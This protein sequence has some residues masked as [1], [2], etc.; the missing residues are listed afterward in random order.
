M[1]SN[2]STTIRS[3]SYYKKDNTKENKKIESLLKKSE[4]N[5]EKTQ[6]QAYPNRKA[7]S[8]QH[9]RSKVVHPQTATRSSPSLLYGVTEEEQHHHS[10]SSHYHQ[11]YSSSP[12]QISHND[13]YDIHHDDNSSPKRSQ[14]PRLSKRT[15]P[16]LSP[17]R[18]NSPQLFSPVAHPNQLYHTPSNNQFDEHDILG[19]RGSI[20]SETSL[21]SLST[22]SSVVSFSPSL[23]G[24][25]I[26][27]FQP[28]PP[29]ISLLN[30][31]TSVKR[32]QVTPIYQ[33]SSPSN[34]SSSIHTTPK[35][36]TTL[37]SDSPFTPQ[38][39]QQVVHSP[40]VAQMYKRSSN[41]VDSSNTSPT[42]R[43]RRSVSVNTSTSSFQTNASI[44]SL[45]N[46]NATGPIPLLAVTRPETPPCTTNQP[47]TASR[48][49]STPK[50]YL[51]VTM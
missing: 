28:H 16:Q 10:P 48:S 2:S 42:H 18:S 46:P 50:R 40:P 32:N 37:I 14:S 24:V 22:S 38:I 1:G 5:Y 19:H 36:R 31:S 8:H 9:L 29:M 43:S 49:Q 44:T 33:P 39:S 47:N 41:I 6:K 51:S 4:H 3:P 25:M 17:V 21:S 13:Y 27:A 12:I 7:N 35:K 23:G 15:H 30:R 45:F 20:S 34:F 26:P 11:Q